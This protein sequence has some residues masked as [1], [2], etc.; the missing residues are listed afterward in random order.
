MTVQNCSV[1]ATLMFIPNATYGFYFISVSD[2]AAITTGGGGGGAGEV[3]VNK[4]WFKSQLAVLR[5]IVF[6]FLAY[7]HKYG[8][9]LKGNFSRR[10]CER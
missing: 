8:N 1:A 3:V 6:F 4:K 7:K 10:K 9:F 5:Y 2:F